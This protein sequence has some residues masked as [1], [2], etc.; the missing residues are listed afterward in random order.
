MASA[1]EDIEA[2][3]FTSMGQC[4]E[5][6]DKALREFGLHQ[7][8]VDISYEELYLVIAGMLSQAPCAGESY[9]SSGKAAAEW[10]AP[11]KAH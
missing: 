10:P 4:F 5:N 2:D 11:I 6:I 9:V 3:V 1:V 8:F 7:R